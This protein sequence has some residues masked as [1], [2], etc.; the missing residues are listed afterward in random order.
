MYIYFLLSFVSSRYAVSI[1]PRFTVFNNNNN[2]NQHHR[3]HGDHDYYNRNRSHNAN[4]NRYSSRN[5][6]L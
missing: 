1:C 3:H 2:I 4:K 5:D 6:K